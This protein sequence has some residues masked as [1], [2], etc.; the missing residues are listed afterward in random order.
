MFQPVVM[1]PA[2]SHKVP[3]GGR[4]TLAVR[5]HM[6]K[7]AGS[8]GFPAAREPARPIPGADMP[9][10][11]RR[12][13]PAPADLHHTPVD[14]VGQQ[15]PP[16]GLGGKLTG[17]PGG[18]RPI[19]DEFP[20]SVGQPEQRRQRDDHPDLDPDR[21]IIVEPTQQKVGQDVGAAFIR[22]AG[23][24]RGGGVAGQGVD[25]LVSGLGIRCGQQRPQL[26]H[27]VLDRLDPYR[28][29]PA[30]LGVAV[31]GAGGVDGEHG[32]AQRLAEQG[33]AASPAP[34][35]NPFFHGCG[36]GVGQDAGGLD[37]GADPA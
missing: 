26:G 7:I 19:P 32:P 12:G 34:G 29:F 14:R 18:D 25:P 21:G 33:M 28:A 24:T 16:T 22:A 4:P 37:D 5:P 27:P 11:P 31:R 20:G 10:K 13:E 35:Q 8:G 17:Q 6:I 36:V 15:P 23:I 9:G 30:A 3:R 1:P 2:H